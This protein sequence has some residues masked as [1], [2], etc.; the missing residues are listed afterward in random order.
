MFDNV[1]STFDDKSLAAA[2]SW[3]AGVWKVAPITQEPSI[4]LDNWEIKHMK[5]GDFFMGRNIQEGTGRVSTKVVMFDSETK[6]GVTASGRI[7]QLVGEPG[8]SS[9]AEYVWNYYKRING[10][11]ELDEEIDDSEGINDS[12]FNK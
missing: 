12:E 4:Q 11:T 5:E 10:L 8:Y 1:K 3:G 9:D 7:Y 2:L 6:K